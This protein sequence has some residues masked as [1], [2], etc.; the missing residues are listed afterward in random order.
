MKGKPEVKQRGVHA[1]AG[2]GW[3]RRLIPTS[4]RHA[5]RRQL[6]SLKKQFTQRGTRPNVYQIS[7]AERVGVVFTAPSEMSIDERLL[8]YALV[9]GLRP[10]RIL[11]IGSREGGSASIMANALEDVG[12]DGRIVGLDP[13]PKVSVPASRFHGRFEVIAAASPAG[14]P[15]ARERAGEPF[16]FALI[17]GLHTY[18]QVVQDI[19]ACL[20]HLA[21]G[22]YL[23]FH[24]AFH[25]GVS[26]AIREAIEHDN[27]LHDCGYLSSSVC[28]DDPLVAYRGI[29]V[30]RFANQPVADPGVLIE[31]GYR[32]DGLTP[33]TPD[34]DLRNH[35]GW[36]C[37]YFT[38]CP[39]CRA[40]GEAVV[41]NPR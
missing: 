35:D 8:L 19:A 41:E 5:A 18:D 28:T 27:R 6:E 29:R 32:A 38:P 14:L 36:Y 30:V 24:D 4:W 20:P 21:D 23:V 26:E 31:R 37:R 10:R 22:A 40:R 11:E 15:A 34:P 39:R 16:D 12:Q 33:P 9:R 13:Q 2:P 25:L 1:M 17:D 7:S 3:L